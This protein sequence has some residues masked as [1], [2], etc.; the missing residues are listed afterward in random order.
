VGQSSYIYFF[1]TERQL[2]TKQASTPLALNPTPVPA[3]F[4]L[5]PAGPNETPV[6]KPSPTF[7]PT[8]NSP[9]PIRPPTSAAVNSNPAPTPVYP[10]STNWD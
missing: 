5:A 3:T 2:P 10:A 9:F 1:P 8:D 6:S 7:P 4:N